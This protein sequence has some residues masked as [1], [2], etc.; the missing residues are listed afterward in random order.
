MFELKTLPLRNV[1]QRR[2]SH[3]FSQENRG[4]LNDGVEYLIVT[5]FVNQYVI[6]AH[7]R[8]FAVG[9]VALFL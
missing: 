4:V 8:S 7:I 1:Y 2:G 3:C 5:D 9:T 6:L